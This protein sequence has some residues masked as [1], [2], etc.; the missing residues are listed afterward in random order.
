MPFLEIDGWKNNGDCVKRA[1]ATEMQQRRV[2][3]LVSGMP[4]EAR[5]A[6]GS[7]VE[8]ESDNE[9][10]GSGVAFE[11]R[12]V[13]RGQVFE[14]ARFI[15]SELGY[16]RVPIEKRHERG[17]IIGLDA[18]SECTKIRKMRMVQHV[19]KFN[20]LIAKEIKAF[21]VTE[22]KKHGGDGFYQM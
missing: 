14:W 20:T 16:R 21:E 5:A 2:D 18:I 19:R 12:Q 11:I 10:V 4:E 15:E 3:V 7:A 1:R 13:Y 6:D 9:R 22:L 8:I 17:R